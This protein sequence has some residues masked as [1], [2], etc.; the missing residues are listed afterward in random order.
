MCHV[1]LAHGQKSEQLANL[2][3]GLPLACSVEPYAALI[4]A[5]LTN[6]MC[7]I[8][9]GVQIMKLSILSSTFLGT[10]IHI[11]NL[12][13]NTICVRPKQCYH[14]EGKSDTSWNLW[15]NISDN[16]LKWHLRKRKGHISVNRGQKKIP[17]RHTWSFS[18]TK[19]LTQNPPFTLHTALQ[20]DRDQNNNASGT[21]DFTDPPCP[22]GAETHPMATTALVLPY[23]YVQST[24]ASP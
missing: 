12:F 9:C 2:W 14:W 19:P 20:L 18:N 8:W 6:Q 10:N 22:S 21:P 4:D 11:S 23:I 1:R 5:L 15:T 16:P 3:H 24:V 17:I 7:S 13:L